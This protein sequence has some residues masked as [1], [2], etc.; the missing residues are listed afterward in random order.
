[1][2]SLISWGFPLQPKLQFY[3][4]TN[5]LFMVSCGLQLCHT[6]LDLSGSL[7]HGGRIHDPFILASS[8]SPKF[9]SHG[10]YSMA[11]SLRWAIIP[12]AHIS[13][14]FHMLMQLVSRRKQLFWVSPFTSLKISWV[15]SYPEGTLPIVPRKNY[16]HLLNGVNPLNYIPS[17][18]M[19]LG[20]NKLLS[21]LFLSKLCVWC[22]CKFLS[23][24]FALFHCRPTWVTSNNHITDSMLRCLEI[25]SAKETHLSF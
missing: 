6:F 10:W 20:Y 13:S 9:V 5:W 3:S 18:L 1:M 21:A 7:N 11:A 12:F 23:I 25:F 2:R 14:A 17:F 22:F 24:L 19:C 4:F 8:M 16:R 15:E